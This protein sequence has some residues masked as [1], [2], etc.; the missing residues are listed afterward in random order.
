MTRSSLGVALAI[1]LAACGRSK[2]RPATPPDI[3]TAPDGSGA[4]T[5]ITM[6]NVTIAATVTASQPGRPPLQRLTLD[7]AIDNRSTTATWIVIPKQIPVDPDD[8][9][10]GVD[11]LEIRGKGTALLGTFLGTGGVHVLRVAPHAKVIVTGLPVGWWRS[12]PQDA[13]PPLLVTIAED[14]KIDGKSADGWFGVQPLVE[15]GARIDAAGAQSGAH[16]YEGGEAPIVLTG[17][18]SASTALTLPAP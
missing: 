3:A 17:A 13:V 8:G 18:Q 7:V 14:L 9:G 5:G 2:E 11:S 10:T 1:L 6:S 16:T 4:P 15:S 12:S